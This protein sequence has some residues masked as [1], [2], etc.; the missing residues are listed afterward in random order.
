VID[1]QT[2]VAEREKKQKKWEAANAE[3]GNT[4]AVIA[5]DE[6][7]LSDLN[8][9]MDNAM[10]DL[11][12]LVEDY[13]RLSLAGSFSKHVEKAIRLLEERY[14][15]MVQKGVSKAQLDNIQDGLDVMGRKLEVLMRRGTRGCK[16]RERALGGEG[17]PKFSILY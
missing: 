7:E 17:T 4:E 13:G 10:D 5:A 6:R 1:S 12:R 9:A 2:L 3:K 15:D 14:T 16:G 8:H 11:T